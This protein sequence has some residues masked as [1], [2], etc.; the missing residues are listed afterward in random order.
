MSICYDCK[1]EI[2]PDKDLIDFDEDGNSYHWKCLSNKK[3][4]EAEES[5]L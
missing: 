1:K 5:E 4:C 2:F 3:S